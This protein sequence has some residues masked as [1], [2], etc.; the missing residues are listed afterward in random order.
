MSVRCRRERRSQ[1]GGDGTQ[2]REDQDLLGSW[3]SCG[4][5]AMRSSPKEVGRAGGCTVLGTFIG[6]CLPPVS[7]QT[8]LQDHGRMGSPFSCHSF[9]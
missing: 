4:F 1:S 9:V 2:H 5:M 8:C 6:V 7:L 3:D